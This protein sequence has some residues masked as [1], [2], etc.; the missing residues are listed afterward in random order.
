MRRSQSSS[1]E[2]GRCQ[3]TSR[4]IHVS[5]SDTLAA[6]ASEADDLICLFQPDPFYAIG[7]HYRDFRQLGDDDVVSLLAEAEGLEGKEPPR[8]R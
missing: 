6:L 2:R 1:L 4:L 5:P 8:S 3:I 7:V